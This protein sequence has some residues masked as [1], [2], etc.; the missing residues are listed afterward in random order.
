MSLLVHKE[1]RT[2]QGAKRA[3]LNEKVE[4]VRL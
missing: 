4:R 2:K 3:R 1:E